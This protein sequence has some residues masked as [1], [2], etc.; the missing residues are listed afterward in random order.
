[1]IP[2][3]YRSAQARDDPH[4]RSDPRPAAAPGIGFRTGFGQGTGRRAATVRHGNAPFTD[5]RPQEVAAER[6]EK[7]PAKTRLPCPSFCAGCSI[8]VWAFMGFSQGGFMATDTFRTPAQLSE[9]QVRVF[10]NFIDGEW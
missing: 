4:L 3:G 10:K 7:N 6:R 1:M 9:S 8:R 2:R 5:S